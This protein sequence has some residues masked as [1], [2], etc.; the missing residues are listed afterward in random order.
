MLDVERCYRVLDVGLEAS[1]EEIHQG[2]LDMIWVWH[3]DRFVGHPRL[4]QKAHHKLQEL[5]E[6]HEQLRSRQRIAQSQH[7]GSKS[8]FWTS[9]TPQHQSSSSL[10]KPQ[11][12]RSW[13]EQQKPTVTETRHSVS[14]KPNNLDDWLD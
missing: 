14:F 2:Y 1:P 11:A 5:N 4:Q 12:H 3:P 6:A 8:K 9:P 13:R 7:L 10:Y